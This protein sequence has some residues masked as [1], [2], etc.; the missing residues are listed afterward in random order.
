MLTLADQSAAASVAASLDIVTGGYPFYAE[1]G[2]A[3]GILWSGSFGTSAPD[4]TTLMPIASA[5]KWVYA[6][7]IAQLKTL[8]AD[9]WPYLNMTSGYHSLNGQCQTTS[10]ETVDS[11][12]LTTGP[13]GVP[14]NTLTAGDVGL[15][16]YDGGHWQKHADANGLATDTRSLLAQQYRTSLGFDTSLLFTQPLIAGGITT[17]ADNYRVLLQALLN[18]TINLA[19]VLGTNQVL[20]SHYLDPRVSSPAPT[21]EPW[22]FSGAGH[23]VEPDG[24]LCSAGRNGFYAWIDASRT[25]YGIV[26]R[27]DANAIGGEIGLQG[28]RTGQAIRNAFMNGTVAG[29]EKYYRAS[30]VLGQIN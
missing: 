4:N 21:D 23:W 2:N 10:T 27:N 16:F 3:S 17:N 29:V 13:G 25:H 24:T 19:A 1:I 14:Y 11:C 7:V 20:A 12:W 26:A 28:V 15:F 5:S 30:N 9:D 6:A 22:H 8:G 18:G